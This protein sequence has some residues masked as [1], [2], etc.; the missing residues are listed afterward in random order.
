M[1]ITV[2]FSSKVFKYSINLIKNPKNSA[3]IIMD[4]NYYAVN[5]IDMNDYERH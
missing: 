2:G 5:Q 1:K 4:K 3:N